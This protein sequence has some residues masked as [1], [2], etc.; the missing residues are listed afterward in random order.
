M[1]AG[2]TDPLCAWNGEVISTSD[3]Q[4]FARE[5]AL[6][7]G[8]DAKNFTAAALRSGGASDILDVLGPKEGKAVIG[9]R[10]RWASDIDEI[11]SRL[12]LPGQL[13]A[14]RRMADSSGVEL[15]SVARHW[16]QPLRPLRR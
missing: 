2:S 14:S 9:P 3:V 1:R 10:G 7:C 16:R 8:L 6:A 5:V 15:E 4:S 13:E 11:Y 12:S